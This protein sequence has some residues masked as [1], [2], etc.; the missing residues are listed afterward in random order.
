MVFTD[1]HGRNFFV[2]EAGV[3]SGYFDLES[4]QAAPAA[5]EF[6]GFRF[7]LF[8]FFDAETFPKAEAAFFKGY[9]A[10]GGPCAPETAEDEALIQLLSG[11]RLLELSESYWGVVDAV[12]DTWGERMKALLL[13]YMETGEIDYPALGQL[14]RQRDGQPLHP[15]P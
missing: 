11:C 1:M 4:S 12:R 7:F 3:P 8:N 14:W 5:L 13:R 9:R 6:Y 10:A 15:Q 2:D